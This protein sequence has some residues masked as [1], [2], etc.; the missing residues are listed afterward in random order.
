M[1]TSSLG[2]RCHRPSELRQWSFQGLQPIGF[3]RVL[4][5]RL[6]MSPGLPELDGILVFEILGLL[7]CERLRPVL[8]LLLQVCKAGANRQQRFVDVRLGLAQ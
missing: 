2:E 6:N 4:D 1:I 5:L 7:V 3:L 8:L